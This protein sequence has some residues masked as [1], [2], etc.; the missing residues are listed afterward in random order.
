[1]R[2]RHLTTVLLSISLLVTTCLNGISVGVF[3]EQRQAKAESAQISNPRIDS[4]GVVTWDCVYFGR[5]W[6]EDTNGD[7]KADQND[8]KQPIK[9]RVLSVDG[10]DM[11]LL[12]DKILDYRRYNEEYN[13]VTWETSTLRSW[14]NGYDLTKN[15]DKKNYTTSNF[16]NTAFSEK[17]KMDIVN[18]EIVTK[19]YVSGK[20]QDDTV[21]KVFLL[22]SSEAAN[23]SYGF[24]EFFHEKSETRI[25]T[26]TSYASG[27]YW[28][29]NDDMEDW[30][31]LRSSGISV[32]Y[33][34]G[35]GEQ[36]HTVDA[37][38]AEWKSDSVVGV[39]PALHLSLSSF[40]WDFADAVSIKDEFMAKSTWD[41]VYFGHYWQNDTN[42]DGKADENDEK[43]PIKWRVLSI[44]NGS[45]LL[46]SDQCLDCKRYDE[47]YTDT[48][49]ENCT[50]RSWLNG[51]DATKNGDG[52]DYL[53]DNF[54]YQ[55]F[56]D[57]EQKDIKINTDKNYTENSGASDKVFLL[58]KSDICNPL[59]GFRE[60]FYFGINRSL[61]RKATVS[62]YAESKGVGI[63][64]KTSLATND[65]T[66]GDCDINNG[67][68]WLLQG[69]EKAWSFITA[70]G[71]YGEIDE[72]IIESEDEDEVGY[73][74]AVK[75]RFAVRPALYLSVSSSHWTY[76]GTVSAC[77]A[78][79]TDNNVVAPLGNLISSPSA[80]PVTSTSSSPFVS[81]VVS[82][83]PT[84]TPS[85]SPI[86]T[87]SPFA[88]PVVSPTSMVSA[89]P[90]ASA[91]TS[92]TPTVSPA[93]API[94]T[95]VPSPSQTPVVTQNP[96]ATPTQTP[97][98]ATSAPDS[99][100][101]PTPS[102][103]PS[104]NESSYVPTTTAPA[105]TYTVKSVGKMQYKLEEGNHITASFSGV[106]NKNKKSVEIPSS[107]MIDGSI[108]KITKIEAGAF[109]N[110]KKLKSVKFGI[111]V[112]EIGKNAFK[113]CSK[114]PFIILPKKLKTIGAGAFANC[115]KLK[116]WVINSE[117][118]ESVGKDALKKV[119]GTAL[120]KTKKKLI[121][122]YR[123]LFT[124]DG[125]L[126]KKATF[127]SNP[128]KIKYNGKTY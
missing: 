37:G 67:G 109:K 46:L 93:V 19:Y 12:A 84:V 125:N 70:E 99:T 24:Q 5:Y 116:Y 120:L 75:N 15:E 41:C 57:E 64:S 34:D 50:L 115:K 118:I 6:Q 101:I 89:S 18:S 119:P 59:Y 114:L 71:N 91:V 123:K 23:A 111:H 81:T 76:A 53:N 124:E 117:G 86:V 40:F 3:N 100:A 52:K 82:P 66:F 92:P 55:A 7:G 26:P 49:W 72:D 11:F 16:I 29:V 58:E 83:T 54:I 108:Y 121:K 22:S 97:A 42:G 33:P 4:N 77:G 43:Q 96:T 106:T 2:N 88:S 107:V 38:E 61:T 78:T 8:E 104:P 30:W 102:T 74:S 112:E 79:P 28:Y 69:N 36:S 98:S 9:W 20:K 80:S 45:M 85:A 94:Y 44:A 39:R 110:M 31:W 113:G 87:A 47:S 128:K 32:I 90:S 1:M 126:T 127:I 95:Q 105:K 51:Y 65:D 122:K 60:A 14:L 103:N 56:N 17:E 27:L 73:W 25:C 62:L 13:H 63:P 21:D 48:L 10:D 35:N 68:T